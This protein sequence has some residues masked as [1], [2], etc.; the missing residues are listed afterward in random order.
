MKT[1]AMATLMTLTLATGCTAVKGAASA[2]TG[3]KPH[4]VTVV[5]NINVPAALA[6][7]PIVVQQPAPVAPAPVVEQPAP[8][9]AQPEAP[10]KN[11]AGQLKA[12]GA[13]ALAGAALGTVVGYAM[14]G[15]AGAK[16]GAALG[17]GAGAVGG[18]VANETK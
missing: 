11:R 7:Q 17:A 2:L 9:L 16:K 13:G 15:N 1:L 18:V 3:G 12:L 5:N 14:G 8:W 10:R 4:H 6:P